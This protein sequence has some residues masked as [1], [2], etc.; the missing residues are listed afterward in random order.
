MPSDLELIKKEGW[1]IFTHEG[2]PTVELYG[3]KFPI[4]HP[5]AIHGKLYRDSQNPEIK[6][7]HLK[8]MHDYLWPDTDWHYWTER[9]F[10]AH[11]EGWKYITY[12][13]G[14]STSKSHDAAK[15]A[16]LFWLADPR[17]RAV[18]VASTSLA[19]L[20]SRIWGYVTKFLNESVLKFT[21]K[22][23]MG[24]PPQ[25]LYNR[26]D[27]IHG[28]FAVAAKQGDDDASIASWIGRHPKKGL[29]MV[30]DEAT[31]MPPAI[32]KAVPN[33]EASQEFFQLMAIGN[34]LSKFDLHGSLSTPAAGWKS[35]DP[36]KDSRWETTQKNGICL[37]FSCYESPAIHE[38]DEAKRLRLGKFLITK[39]EVTAKEKLYG[40]KSDAFYRFIL[41][42]WREDTADDTVI[43][44]K[45]LH[46]FN[47]KA[48]AEWSGLYP[49]T[50]VAGLDP[51][52]SQGGDTCILRL[53]ILGH[54]TNGQMI[55][56]YQN[57][58]LLFNIPISATSGISAELQIADAVIRIMN[59]HRCSL[60]NLAVDANGQGRALAE[61]IKLRARSLYTPLKIYSTRIGNKATKSFDVIIKT[62]FE[63]WTAVRDFIQTDQIRGLDITSV[64]QLTSRLIQIKG[65]KQVLE[66]KKDYK[67]RMGSVSPTLAHSPDEA[68]SAALALQVAM[69]NH[70]FF[71]GMKREINRV[72]GFESEK[73][74]E[75]TAQ[76]RAT[77]EDH[78][79]DGPPIADFLG[80]M[81]E[82]KP[83]SLD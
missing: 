27:Q 12:A 4:V 8:A 15:I 73:Y 23:M 68:D 60:Q 48:K 37:F 13:G 49:L 80:E 81:A 63:M 24:A 3:Q 42:F 40:A 34:S 30:L 50:V 41:G 54:A 45:F 7:R 11:C 62:N 36:T 51:A 58:N 17:H 5:F 83:G 29:L 19:S 46:E 10:E 35:I 20:N 76:A 32:L 75:F 16:L 66:S 82:I 64:M 78:G 33:L 39:E 59:D 21:Y 9:R 26:K 43:S 6:Y 28:M 67:N 72:S 25:I 71:P 53:A 69:L 79:K 52:F 56:D 70:G 22:M 77:R 65:S 55:L 14:A 2:R 57:Q 61:V 18:I 74:L 1:E 47:V 31:D 38:P 44:S